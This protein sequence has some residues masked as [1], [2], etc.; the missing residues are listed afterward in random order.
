MVAD[1]G[2][3]EDPFLLEQESILEDSSQLLTSTRNRVEVRARVP[4]AE[5]FLPTPT[6]LH[7]I[8]DICGRGAFKCKKKGDN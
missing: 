6:R 3:E 8:H 4:P 7:Q 5:R 1:Q 2:W